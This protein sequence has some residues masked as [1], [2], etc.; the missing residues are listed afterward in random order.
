MKSIYVGLLGLL[1]ALTACDDNT[2]TLGLYPDT[3]EIDTSDSILDVRTRTSKLERIPSNST[4]CYLG[5]V[6]D[7]ETNAEIKSEFLAQFNTLENYDLPPFKDMVKNE[8]GEIEADSVELRLYF[9][10]YFGDANNPMKV[11][12]YEL[13]SENIIS[14]EGTYYSDINLSSYAKPNTAPLARK[15]FTATDYTVDENTSSSSD[16]YKNIRIILPKEYGTYILRKYYENPQFFENSYTFIRNVCP[17][18]YFQLAG[19]NGTMLYLDVS[20]LNIYFR[21]M[22]DE[23]VIDGMSRFA[24]TPEVIQSNR[25]ENSNLD[26]LVAQTQCTYLKTPAGLCTEMT[27]PIDEIYANHPTDSVSRAQITLTRYNSYEQDKYALGTPQTL[28]M[29]RKQDMETFFGEKKVADGHTS[30]TTSFDATYNTYTFS[31]ISRLI[32]FCRN[33]KQSEARKLGITP[34]EWAAQNPDWNKVMLIPVTVST[35]T[36]GYQVSVTHDMKMNSVR[37]VGGDTPIR[38][39][40]IYSKFN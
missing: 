28:L 23:N 1:L 12:V 26:D 21:Y 19:G 4:T 9:E 32:S 6:T 14:E 16:Y 40:V 22:E 25:I 11:N 3:D 10:D 27:L 35:N 39:Q 34:E 13:D 20:T 7:P 17:G 30:Y 8:A 5:R 36:S 37:L 33:E 15:V 24:A 31:N 18:F 38:M 29:V 2:S